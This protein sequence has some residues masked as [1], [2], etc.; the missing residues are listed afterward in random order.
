MKKQIILL[1]W[2]TAKENYKDFYDFVKRY[3]I[4]PYEEKRIKWSDV[5]AEDLWEDFEVL[6]IERL[7]KSFAD[8]RARE[9]MFEKYI[10]YIKDGAILVGHSLG[11]SFFLKYFDKKPVLLERVEKLILVAPAIE[12]TEEELIGGFEVDLNF[13]NLK[14]YQDKIAV[15]AS[16]NDD[17]VPI[18]QTYKL[19]KFLPN[20]K[21]IILDWK[22][23][24]GD[25]EF[26]E[27]IEEIKW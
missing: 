22:K 24:F 21:Y 11:W 23:H 7:L 1:R 3:E 20:A 16:K 14:N 8:Y 2:G 13:K 9:M 27:L 18:W 26:K 5:L 4:D 6:E 25:R 15:F 19:Q 10:P 12:D 17:V